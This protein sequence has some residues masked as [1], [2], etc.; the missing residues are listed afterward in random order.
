M[1]ICSKMAEFHYQSVL[2][3]YVPE[4]VTVYFYPTLLYQ[5]SKCPK[6]NKT[7]HNFFFVWI[8]ASIMFAYS[9]P[10]TKLVLWTN[11]YSFLLMFY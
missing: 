9:I 2:V 7:P 11:D 3:I 8:V 6:P 4:K 10:T 5:A 1:L